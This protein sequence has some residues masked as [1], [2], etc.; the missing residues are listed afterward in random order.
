ME[1]AARPSSGT[2]IARTIAIGGRHI[3][4]AMAGD[5]GISFDDADAAKCEDGVFSSGFES[6]SPRAV[7]VGSAALPAA[8]SSRHPR[9]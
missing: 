6:T 7:A 1:G 2:P 5:L 3:T 4:E 9:P 8:C